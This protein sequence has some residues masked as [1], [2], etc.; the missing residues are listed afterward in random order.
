MGHGTGDNPQAIIEHSLAVHYR[1]FYLAPLL[2]VNEA[3]LPLALNP[4]HLMV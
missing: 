2:A 3:L 4:F 1:E